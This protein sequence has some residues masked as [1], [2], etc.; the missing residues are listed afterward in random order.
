MTLID[1]LMAVP[2]ESIGLLRMAQFY[3]DLRESGPRLD[4]MVYDNHLVLDAEH[5][6]HLVTVAEKWG[7]PLGE[8]VYSATVER[9]GTLL[10]AQEETP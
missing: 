5:L 7:V 6:D 2:Y 8:P 1:R 4:F 10:H 9:V 3:S